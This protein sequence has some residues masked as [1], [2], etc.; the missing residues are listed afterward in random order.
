MTEE[1]KHSE[2]LCFIT[3]KRSILPLDSLVKICVDFYDEDEIFSARD[4]LDPLLSTP[5]PKRKSADKLRATVE[6]TVKALLNS[7][8]DLPTFYAVSIARLPPVDAKHCD[9]S[10]VLMELQG[11][12]REVRDIQKL[13]DEVFVLRQQLADMVSLRQEVDSLKQLTSCMVQSSVSSAADTAGSSH[14]VTA[15]DT[16]SFSSVAKALQSTGMKKK[17]TKCVVGK[18]TNNVRVKLVTTKRSIDIICFTT[19]PS[20]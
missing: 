14:C 18:S 19:A 6:D 1:K 10:A 3:D 13:Q 11:L 2:L 16:S 7:S 4:L 5:L 17:E 12:R 20:N 15:T 9:M 8:V